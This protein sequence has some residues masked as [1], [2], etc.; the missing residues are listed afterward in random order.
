MITFDQLPHAVSELRNEFRNEIAEIKRL[1]SKQSE[2]DTVPQWLSVK[3]LINY[4]PSKPAK[5]TIYGLVNNKNIPC[6]R[7]NGRLFFDKS[8]INRWLEEK[9]KLTRTEIEEKASGLMKGG[10]K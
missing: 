2:A 1:I 6:H 7:I 10:R 5:Q 9:R 8:E 3:D 4:L